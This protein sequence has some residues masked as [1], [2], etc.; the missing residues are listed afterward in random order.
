M[1]IT[2]NTFVIVLLLWVANLGWSW[3]QS[4]QTS[5]AIT[6]DQAKV[7]IENEAHYKSWL[8]ELE[9]PGVQ[10][11]EDQMIF[12]EEAKRLMADK[13]YRNSVYSASGYSFEDVSN[14]L[15]NM[16]IQKAF[17]QLLDL[18]PENKEKVLKYIYAYD[19][20]LPSDRVLTAS[21]YTYAFFDPKITSLESGKPDVKRPDIFEEYMRRTRE[22][23]TY[24]Q[25][26]R[27]N[28]KQKQS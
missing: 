22:I 14:S 7:M 25:Y 13:D 4:E 16:E 3:A 9:T 8:T 5:T 20:S 12:S 10:V 28:D 19:S 23:V 15:G 6:A 27:E 2:K 11:T 1:Q 17:W 24:I 26:F 18:Y 21:F